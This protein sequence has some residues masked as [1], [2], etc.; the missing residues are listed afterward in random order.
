MYRFDVVENT[1]IGTVVGQVHATDIDSGTFGQI[2]YYF[3]GPA[4]VTDR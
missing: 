2:V 3:S 1:A 4:E